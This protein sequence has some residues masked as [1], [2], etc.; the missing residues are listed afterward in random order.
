MATP[1]PTPAPTPDAMALVVVGSGDVQAVARDVLV[2]AVASFGSEVVDEASKYEAAR[3]RPFTA[4][5]DYSASD[6]GQA[7]AVVRNRGVMPAPRNAGYYV[8]RVLQWLLTG[9]AGVMGGLIPTWTGAGYFLAGGAVAALM[10]TAF[11]EYSDFKER[12][13][14]KRRR[15]K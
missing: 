4:V 12:N 2:A 6:I 7:E 5:V 3:N 15:R 9:F 10:F 13:G 1:T 8:L 11:L 14:G